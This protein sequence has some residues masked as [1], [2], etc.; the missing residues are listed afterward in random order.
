MDL[1]HLL[2]KVGIDL[3]ESSPNLLRSL[4]DLTL[5]NH[6]DFEA[7]PR[8]E[9]V[10]VGILVQCVELHLGELLGAE[11]ASM[12]VASIQLDD[13]MST[14]EHICMTAADRLLLDE[15]N[16]L[17]LQE[18]VNLELKPAGWALPIDL[19]HHLGGDAGRGL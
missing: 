19:A 9:S 18:G 10:A 4:L 16:L 13:I 8:E 17:L 11:F 7:K 15:G 5:P 1:R 14:D 6:M 2:R 12:P 3:L